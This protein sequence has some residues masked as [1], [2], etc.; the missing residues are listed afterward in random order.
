[1]PE[2]PVAKKQRAY[3]QLFLTPDQTLPEGPQKLVLADLAQF[4]YSARPPTKMDATGRV[5][6]LATAQAIGRQEVWMRIQAMIHLPMREQTVLGT[7]GYEP[8]VD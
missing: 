2:H 7:F 6:A 3:R 4:C 1:M 5:D 8:P